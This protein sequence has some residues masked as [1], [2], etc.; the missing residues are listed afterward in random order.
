MITEADRQLI[1]QCLD[2]H[3]AAFGVRLPAARVPAAMTVD[4]PDLEGFVAWRMIPSTVT[5]AEVLGLEESVPGPFP[6][7][8]RAYLT[9]RH[10][11]GMDWFDLPDLPSDDPLGGVRRAL[12][13]QQALLAAG[14]LPFTESAVGGIGPLCFDLVS[15]QPDGD[16][17]VVMFDRDELRPLGPQPTREELEALATVTEPSF[18]VMLLITFPEKMNEPVEPQV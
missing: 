5:E 17:P 8:F 9:T 10:T 3:F 12:A 4:E 6:P 13:T 11:L 15:R 2:N 18:R 7:L 1:E 16:C 14:Y